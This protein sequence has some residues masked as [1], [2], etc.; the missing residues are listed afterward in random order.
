MI[1]NR[2]AAQSCTEQ[3]LKEARD[4]M[5]LKGDMKELFKISIYR[6]NLLLLMTIWSFG[7]FSFFLVPYYLAT[8]DLNVFLMST[9]TALGE[10][11]ASGICW[12]ITSCM[13]IKKSLSLFSFVTFISSVGI[14]VYNGFFVTIEPDGSLAPGESQAPEAACYLFLY[15]GVT[16]VFDLVYLIVNELFPTI[17]TATAYGACNVLGRFIT[18][19][20]PLVARAPHPWPMIILTC[21]SLICVFVPM[22]LIKFK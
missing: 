19:T 18:I 7:A 14:M 20:A 16:C 6:R 21:Y 10:I 3:D 5:K 12:F 4:E 13:P 1:A 2:A 22:F 9:M 11:I 8:I 15:V 17:F